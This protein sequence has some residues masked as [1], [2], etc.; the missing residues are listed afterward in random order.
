MNL[1]W[2]GLGLFIFSPIMQNTQIG[3]HDEEGFADMG[4]SLLECHFI[5]R[6]G[7]FGLP[8]SWRIMHG[9]DLAY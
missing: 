5:E 3:V 4:V 7:C 1:H 2:I 8:G 6:T 9:P